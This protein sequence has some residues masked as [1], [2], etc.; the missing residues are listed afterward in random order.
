MRT[1][2][3]LYADASRET[4]AQGLAIERERSSAW[5]IDLVG[6]AERREQV[7]ATNRARRHPRSAP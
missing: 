7:M 5:N 1:L 3:V 2:K 6:P 4:P